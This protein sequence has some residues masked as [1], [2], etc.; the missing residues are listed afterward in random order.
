M[1]DTQVIPLWESR[2]GLLMRV[3]YPPNGDVAEWIRH[4]P[5]GPRTRS[6]D[7]A[8]RHIARHAHRADEPGDDCRVCGFP[9][10]PGPSGGSA[11]G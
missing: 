10:W 11:D 8:G 5:T 1:D 2:H 6:N 7:F 9:W 4:G 3:R